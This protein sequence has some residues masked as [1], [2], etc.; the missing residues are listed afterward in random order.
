MK[1]K[2]IAFLLALPAFFF[3]A[4]NSDVADVL[5][6]QIQ[7]AGD[8][9]SVDAAVFDLITETVPMERITSRPDSFL[10]GE[11][12]DK[13]MGVLKA[14]VLA[15]FSLFEPG[16]QFLSPDKGVTEVDSVVMSLNFSSSFGLVNTPLQIKI[17]ELKAPLEDKFYA[18]DMDPAPYVDDS[19]LIGEA[20][21]TVIDGVT[22]KRKKQVRLKMNDAFK[23]R[24]FTTDPKHYRSQEDFKAFFPG[25]YITTDFGG[26]TMLNLQSVQLRMHYSY[27]YNTNLSEK[28]SG[29]HDFFVTAGVPRVNRMTYPYRSLLFT[30]KDTLNY[31]SSPANYR[32]R[33]RIPLAKLRERVN[34]GGKTLAV[35]SALIK[36]NIRK[37]VVSDQS[38]IPYVNNL[39]LIKEGALNDFFDKRQALSDTVSFLASRDSVYVSKNN[40][41]YHYEFDGLAKLIAKEIKGSADTLNMVLVPVTPLYRGSGASN[42]VVLSE[43]MQSNL[44]QSVAI[45]SGKHVTRPMKLEV[46]YSG[47]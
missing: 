31:I 35:N 24:F 7:P 8:Q 1:L 38:L 45:Y 16:F 9:I 29:Y 21:F 12:D 28:L 20:R 14:D 10:L 34:T 17:F 41:T 13:Q 3:A 44:L 18:S 23:Q 6:K 36:M 2:D 19:K 40:Y 32:T 11:F 37:K 5:G 4:C 47:F 39:L 33:V 27:A 43:V 42:S 46:I 25:V 15:E 22:G 30:G 26:L